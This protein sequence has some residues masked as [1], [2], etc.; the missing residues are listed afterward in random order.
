[1]ERPNIEDVKEEVLNYILFLE[2]KIKELEEL[3]NSWDLK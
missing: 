2:N 1:M 3:C